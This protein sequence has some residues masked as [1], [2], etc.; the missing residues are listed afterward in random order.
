MSYDVFWTSLGSL[1]FG[2]VKSESLYWIYDSFSVWGKV[3]QGKAG[4]YSSLMEDSGDLR[5]T[6]VGRAR[7]YG[8][9]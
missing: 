3:Y 1:G 4:H 2:P 6:L 8:Y 9:I 5:M 7:A